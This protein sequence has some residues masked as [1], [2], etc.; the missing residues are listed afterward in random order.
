[1]KTMIMHSKLARSMGEY[2]RRTDESSKTPTLASAIIYGPNTSWR[3][4]SKVRHP[5]FKK[6][7]RFHTFVSRKRSI[8][9]MKFLLGA[10]LLGA[11][12]EAVPQL[13]GWAL[14]K[15]VPGTPK[16]RKNAKR[17]VLSYGPFTLMGK[18]DTKSGFS[19]DPKGQGGVVSISGGLPARITILSGHFRLRHVNGQLAEPK[20]GVY[21]HHMVA[22]PVGNT[23]KMPIVGVRGVSTP[24]GFIDRGEDSGEVETVFTT[25]DGKFNS[26][27]QVTSAPRFSV[28]YDVVN[29]NKEKKQ[30]YLELEVEYVDGIQ[31]LDA[32]HTLK[33]VGGKIL[34]KNLDVF[35]DGN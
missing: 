16:Y 14:V 26:G 8:I 3:L 17:V 32:G 23:K 7:R 12:A 27:Y 24:S 11:I 19:M 25:Q 30:L 21:I 10:L 35:W 5:A 33:T 18:D 29:Y 28:Q 13:G 4:N 6:L 22:M 31:G 2:Q 15:S 34:W 9:T 1:L 20:N